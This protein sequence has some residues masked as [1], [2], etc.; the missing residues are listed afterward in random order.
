MTFSKNIVFIAAALIFGLAACTNGN[1][2]Q[3]ETAGEKEKYVPVTIVPDTVI[4]VTL[5]DSLKRVIEKRGKQLAYTTQIVLKG[6]LKKA[7]KAGGPAHAV[8]FC[9]DRAMKITDSMSLAN[10]VQIRRIAKKFRNPLNET[11]ENESNLFKGYVINTLGGSRPFSTVAWDTLGRPVFYYPI[12][13]DA[14]C[15]NCHGTPGTEIHDDVAKTIA[16]LYPGDKAT[17][18]KLHDLRALWAISFPEYRIV[19]IDYSDKKK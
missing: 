8:S 16:E 18:F 7:I 5:N 3:K 9:Y 10:N 4:N 6:E 2:K 14:V 13:V 12:Y 17:G 15:L 19:D 1:T 11:D